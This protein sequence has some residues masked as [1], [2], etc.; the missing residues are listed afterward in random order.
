MAHGRSD[1][2]KMY[3]II[4]M[5]YMFLGEDGS[6]IFTSLMQERKEKYRAAM[7]IVTKGISEMT[8]ERVAE[9][10]L[11]FGYQTIAIKSE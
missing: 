8:T 10:I 3:P 11:N 4:S 5:D 2:D 7:Q 9:W 6:R 1:N